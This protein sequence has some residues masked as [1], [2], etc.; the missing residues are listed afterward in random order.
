MMYPSDH[1]LA[2]ARVLR[3]IEIIAN[4]PDI[5]N[6]ELVEQLV[7]DGIDPVDAHLLMAFVPTALSYPIVVSMGAS[8]LPWYYTVGKR[9][10]SRRLVLLP[11]KE[12]HYFT[13]ALQWVTE[14]LAM[15]PAARPITLEAFNAV[16]VRSPVLDAANGM[17]ENYGRD[18]LRGGVFAPLVICGV[19]AEEIEAS[20]RAFRSKRRWWQFW[21]R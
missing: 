16:V 14:L 8:N 5:S 17:I 4:R 12:E 11:L 15:D 2:L 20:R 6:E 1:A 13:A 18:A 21:R 10:G 3:V 9:P 19:T 7:S